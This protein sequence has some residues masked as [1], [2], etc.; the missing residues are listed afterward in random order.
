MTDILSDIS[1]QIATIGAGITGINAHGVFNP[2]PANLQSADLPALFTWTGSAS[3]GDGLGEH[4]VETT[5]RFYV[6]VAVISTGQGDP[7]TREAL[8]RPLMEATLAQFRKYTRFSSI[9]WVERVKVVSDSGII[10]LPEYGGK[11]IGFEIALD[12]TYIAPANLQE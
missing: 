2:P 6:Q 5:R 9:D 3:H 10:I 4:F 1:A 11:Y 7:N 8:A 12:V